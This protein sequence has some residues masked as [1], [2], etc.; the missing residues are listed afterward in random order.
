MGD[1]SDDTDDVCALGFTRGD[2]AGEYLIAVDIAAQ[3]SMSGTGADRPSD[4]KLIAKDVQ[5]TGK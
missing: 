4:N 5:Y 3:A 2:D 1:S